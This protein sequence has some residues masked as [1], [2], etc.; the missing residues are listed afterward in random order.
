MMLTLTKISETQ[1]TITLGWTPIPCEGYRFTAEK[2]VKPSHSWD[3]SRSSVRFSKGSAW[4]KVEA[5]GIEDEGVYPPVAP[6]AGDKLRWAPPPL[7]SPITL[8]PTTA[9]SSWRLD[10]SKDYNFDFSLLEWSSHPTDDTNGL[11]I[12]G[13]RNVVN[14][15]GEILFSS[16]NI[17]D[18]GRA[19]IIDD[20]NPAGTVH[21]EGLRIKACNGPTLRTKRR[22]QIQNCHITC[23]ISSASGGVH[24]DIVQV[25]DR[26][27]CAAVRMHRVSG[28][29]MYTGL[30][31]L[32]TPNPLVWEI[33][34]CDIHGLPWGGLP[35][36]L[37]NSCYH[38]SG[39]TPY[40]N[41]PYTHWIASNLWLETGYVNATVRRKLDDVLILR[42]VA[43]QQGL[44]TNVYWPYE[45]TPGPG[46]SGTKYISPNP[47]TGGNAPY[48]LGT[49]QGDFLTFERVPDF[50]DVWTFGKAPVAAGADANGN[51]CAVDAGPEYV[52]PG[53]Q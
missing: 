4:Y 32:L 8:R 17:Q 11:H 53:Y 13:G 31:A 19:I 23:F 6:P 37:H 7:T 36:A 45:I 35:M 24:P 33:Y 46:Q 3:A 48:P 15:G 1:T 10:D 2:Q 22:V 14:I 16:T 20:G 34:D 29:S 40:P 51:F 52:S 30:S 47:P 43:G 38:N 42:H 27:P 25:W 12:I 5:L 50:D 9:P 41:G 49:R 26:G 44:P 18:D 39:N 28:Y 21:L